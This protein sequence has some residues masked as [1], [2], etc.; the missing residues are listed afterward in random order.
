MASVFCFVS[1]AAIFNR[2]G[3]AIGI[4]PV[5]A[6]LGVLTVPYMYCLSIIQSHGSR[7]LAVRQEGV[8]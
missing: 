6:T 7:R 5:A 4:V 1:V 2:F 8:L 3:A